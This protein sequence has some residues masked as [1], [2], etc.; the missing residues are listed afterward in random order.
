MYIYIYIYIAPEAFSPNYIYGPFTDVFAIG[1]AL[2]ILVTGSPPWPDK[3]YNEPH[4]KTKLPENRIID[5]QTR[6]KRISQECIEIINAM[7][8]HD[9]EKRISLAEIKKHPWFTDQ[10]THKNNNLN[11]LNYCLLILL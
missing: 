3:Q 5:L 8:H 10:S 1:C 2:H 7:L 11:L 9:Y 6:S 4:C